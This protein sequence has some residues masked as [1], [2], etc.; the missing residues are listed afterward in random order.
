[1]ESKMKSALVIGGTRGFGKAISDELAKRKFE[2]FTIGRSEDSTFRC[3]LSDKKAFRRILRKIRRSL[4]KIDVLACVAGFARARRPVDLMEKDFEITMQCNLGY[5]SQALDML[6]RNVH[7]AEDGRIITIGS[8]WSLRDD[9]SLLVPYIKAKHKLIE[10]VRENSD[11]NNISCFCVPS[12]KT[13]GYGEVRSSFERI[14]FSEIPQENLGS[15]NKVSKSIIKHSLENQVPG[16][17]CKV[18]PCGKI[19]ENL[20]KGGNKP[21]GK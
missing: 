7:A 9:C 12:M 21:N 3:D 8:K 4:P 17:I 20:M 16:L 6:S 5:V 10:F 15:V 13:P 11:E 2:V 18:S 1:M 19:E 14:G